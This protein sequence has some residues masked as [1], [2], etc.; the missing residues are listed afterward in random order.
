MPDQVALTI[1][2]YVRPGRFAEL[3]GL[4]ADIND[5]GVGNAY[6]PFRDLPGL[7]F[8]RLFVLPAATDLDGAPLP[9]S[10]VYM[11]DVDGT[12]AGHLAALTERAAPGV[13]ALFGHC[14]GYPADPVDN[15]RRVGWLRD[16]IVAGATRY[17][18]TVG[19]GV[20]QIRQEWML[21]DAIGDFLDRCGSVLAGATSVEAHRRVRAF[22]RGRPDLR[23]ALRPARGSTLGFRVGEAAHL[24]AVP[25]AAVALSPALVPVGIAAA[26]RLRQIERGETV[27]NRRLPDAHMAS[28]ERC[29]DFTAQNPFTAVG[30][31]RPELTRRLV[32]RTVL[33]ALGYA[34]RHVYDRDNLAGVRTIHFARWLP[35]DG[36]RRLI[37]ASNYDGSVESY[38][39]DFIDRLAWGLNAVF[40]NGTGYPPTRWLLGGGAHQEHAFKLFLRRNQLPTQVWFSA[41]DRLPARNVDDLAR[42]RDGLTHPL[43]EPAAAAWLALL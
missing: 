18:H 27:D 15:R 9:A 13:D 5:K 35:I 16:R 4:L 26:L 43:T 29:E 3:L 23:W 31:V 39:D 37:F 33:V 14:E 41:Y 1:R 12:L 10:L 22:V 40:S 25:A 28:L 34:M 7:H 42:L 38:M 20:S 21:R 2:A 36:G 30:L 19:R 32:L 6:L 8:A 17:T 11:C 24:V